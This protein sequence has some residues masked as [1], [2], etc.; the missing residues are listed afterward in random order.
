MYTYYSHLSVHLCFSMINNMW[1]ACHGSTGIRVVRRVGGV[2]Y[3][4]WKGFWKSLLG[5]A[6]K[7]TSKFCSD[8]IRISGRLETYVVTCIR[9]L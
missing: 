2:L 8:I 7:Q 5:K 4:G 3:T 9:V 1:F 6:R